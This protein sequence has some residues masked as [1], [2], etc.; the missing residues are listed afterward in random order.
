[1]TFLPFR[2]R[3]LTGVLLV[4]ALTAGAG[5]GLRAQVPASASAS[6][7]LSALAADSMEGR[8]TGTEGYRRAARLVA[9]EM[10]RIGLAPAGDSGFYQRM[11][12]VHSGGGNGRLRLLPSWADLDTV[13]AERR[14]TEVNVVGIL[15]GADPALAGE[16]IIVGAHLDHLGIGRV[17]DGDSIYNGADDDASG[18]VAVLRIAEG[19]RAM[20]AEPP[21]RTIVFVAFA[22]EEMGGLGSRWYLEHPVHPLDRTVAQFQIE[23]IARPDSLAGGPGRAWLTGYERSTMG[24]RLAAA[25]I[26]LVADPRPDQ[27]FFRRSDNYRFAVAGIPAHTLSSYN[28]HA[29]YHRP[30]D[31]AQF[32]DPEHLTAVIDAATRAVHLLSTG[33]RPEWKPGGRPQPACL[34]R[35]P[36]D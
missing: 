11:P 16:A 6:A 5:P 8:R 3:C 21:G 26:P 2:F 33:P 18:V 7:L 1:M 9:A 19:L 13:P 27:N 34:P 36:R 29:D 12:L 31:E 24:E 22:G 35:A 20:A 10:E 32:A 25:G 30:R 23:M 17:V 14:A 28:M 4:T 15:P